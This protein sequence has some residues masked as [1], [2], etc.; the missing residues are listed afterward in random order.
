MYLTLVIA[1]VLSNTTF[2]SSIVFGQI[3]TAPMRLLPVGQDV[4]IWVFLTYFWMLVKEWCRK[5]LLL[6][7]AV[8]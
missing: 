4:I 5:D 1:N 2:T 3:T 6:S 7:L 8:A